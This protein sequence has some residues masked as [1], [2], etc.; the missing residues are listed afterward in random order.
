FFSSRRRHTRSDRDWSS[1]VCSSDLGQ[2]TGQGIKDVG[3]WAAVTV[4]G[5]A[6]AGAPSSTPAQTAPPAS[7][8]GGGGGYTPM[9][10]AGTAGIEIGRASC[11]G[12]G[13]VG[14]GVRVCEE[15]A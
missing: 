1:D 2:A 4:V 9:V 7:S 15:N 6:S 11:R 14:V 10:A 3:T 5:K 8:G 12:R 13:E